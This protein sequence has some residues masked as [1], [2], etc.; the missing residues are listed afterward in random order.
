MDYSDQLADGV[1]VR[2]PRSQ[3]HIPAYEYPNPNLSVHRLV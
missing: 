3:L 2:K 1:E